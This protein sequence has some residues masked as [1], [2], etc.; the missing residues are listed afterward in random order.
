MKTSGIVVTVFLGILALGL[1]V[2]IGKYQAKSEVLIP[3]TGTNLPPDPGPEVSK[4]G[5]HPKAVTEGTEHNFGIMA[6]GQKGEYRFTIK[7]EGQADLKMM[8]RKED[9]TCQCTLGELEDGDTIP[10]GESR[11]VTLK[12]EI[13]VMV[14]TFRHSA[15][16]RTNDPENRLIDFVVTGRVDQRFSLTPGMMWEVGD[17]SQTEPT[18]VKG[19]VF[20]RAIDKFEI[21]SVKTSNP[22]LTVTYLPM[23]AELLAEKGAKSGYEVQAVIAAAPPIGPYAESFALVTDD[24]ISKQ[25]EIRLQGH[26]AG[27]IEFLGPAYRKESSLVAFG[28]FKASD[29]KEVTLSLFVRNFDQDLE[30]LAVE[31]PSERVKF[32]LLKDSKVIGKTRRYQLKV[33]VLPGPPI[34]LVAGPPLKFELKLNH[35]EAASVVLSIRM[36]AI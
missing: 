10:P 33:K 35:P 15:K 26:H 25:I 34:D 18:T 23:S 17:L 11:N 29:G 9:A 4:T 21:S 14:E 30:L 22:N 2:W 28:E 13:K 36:L 20:S 8:A 12:W 3:Q 27:P 19:M 24:E 7:N 1:T 16:V 31:P 32:E 5:P 6:L